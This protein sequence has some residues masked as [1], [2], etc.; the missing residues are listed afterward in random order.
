MLSNQGRESQKLQGS[1]DI[2]FAPDL[3]LTTAAKL[4][5][6]IWPAVCNCILYNTLQMS[7]NCIRM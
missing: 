2:P 6:F 3:P 7:S 5:L 1:F 4:K